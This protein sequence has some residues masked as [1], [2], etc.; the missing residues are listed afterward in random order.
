MPNEAAEFATFI[1]QGARLLQGQPN[2]TVQAARTALTD[3]FKQHE[4]ASGVRL[5]GA[6]WL[7]SART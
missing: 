1:G 7:V 5:P 2:E 4:G 3:F 6:L